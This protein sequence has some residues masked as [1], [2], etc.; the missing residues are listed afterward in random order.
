VLRQHTIQPHDVTLLDLSKAIFPHPLRVLFVF[1]AGVV[2]RD[3]DPGACLVP[4]GEIGV[5]F[6]TDGAQGASDEV[7]DGADFGLAFCGTN[8]LV[9]V[10]E[11]GIVMG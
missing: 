10:W 4:G 9:A 6:R 2:G 8:A 3:V 1:P 5:C 11:K 7:E